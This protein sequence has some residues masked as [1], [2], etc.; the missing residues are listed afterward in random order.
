MSLFHQRKC[1]RLYVIID[2]SNAI[3]TLSSCVINTAG[4][5]VANLERVMRQMP[6]HPALS[7]Q[8][9]RVV[10]HTLPSKVISLSS[11]FS[12]GFLYGFSSR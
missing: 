7:K 2:T 5:N 6:F 3:L 12:S 11:K 4:P 8:C 10:I 9:L 1:E